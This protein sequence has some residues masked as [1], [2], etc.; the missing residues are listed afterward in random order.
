MKN[1]IKVMFVFVFAFVLTK[2]QMGSGTVYFGVN[3]DVV[4]EPS[5]AK[6]FESIK[7]AYDAQNQYGDE[8]E[9]KSI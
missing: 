5:Q 1:V 3:G 4:K 8:W 7:D 9:I 6:V 2:L